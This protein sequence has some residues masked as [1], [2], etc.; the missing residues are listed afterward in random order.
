MKYLYG[1]SVQGIQGF[2]FATNRLKEIVGASEIVEEIATK[3]FPELLRELGVE[4]KEWKAVVMA[5]GNVR[6]L[7]DEKEAVEK[8][9]EVAPKKVMQRA[10]G[11]TLSQAVVEVPERIDRVVIDRLGESLKAARNRQYVALDRSLNATYLVPR[12]ARPAVRKKKVKGE[13]ELFDRATL[14]KMQASDEGKASLLK[15]LK[16]SEMDLKKYPDEMKRMANSKGKIAVI[17][18]DGNGLGMVLQKIGES[19]ERHPEK[20]EEV[21]KEFSLRLDEA[22]G[23]AAK[24]AFKEAF[25]TEEESIRFRPV[26]LGG[27]DLT[28][29]CDADRSLNFIGKFLEYFEE[30]TRNEIGQLGREYGI[31]SIGEGLTACAGVAYCNEKFPFHYAVSLAEELCGVAKK[32]SKSLDRNHPPSSLMFHNIQSSYVDNYEGYRRRELTLE[33]NRGEIRLDFGP[34]YLRE[35][36]DFL[37]TVD[38]LKGAAAAFADEETSPIGK[39][40]NWLDML[41]ESRDLA[42]MALARIVEMA[43]ERGFDDRFLR[44]LHEELSLEKLI[45]SR[46]REEDGKEEVTPIYDILQL[47]SISGVLQ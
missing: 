34:Y 31:E 18:A 23:K 10:Y 24:R 13:E 20:T 3:F 46:Q 29:I 1:A 39:L 7:F 8:L 4:E 45:V 40:R 14:Q 6:I 21:F 5:A 16:V 25:N 30:D 27:D 36:G 15:K 35:Q 33:T 12:T 42:D 17:H 43:Q 9:F 37:P 47:H 28:V 26:V 44:G 2:I 41:E 11:I 22:T 32:E 38:A 19:L